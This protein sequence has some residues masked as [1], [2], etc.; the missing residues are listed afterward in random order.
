MEKYIIDGN[1]DFYAELYKSLDDASDT[2]EQQTCLITGNAL[3]DKYVTLNCG[4]TFNY[5]PLYYDVFNHKKKYNKFEF[6]MC[7]LQAWQFRCPYCRKK[8]NELLPYYPEFNTG[9]VFGVNYYHD[10]V[11]YNIYKNNVMIPGYMCEYVFPGK[12]NPTYDATKPVGPDNP[13]HTEPEPCLHCYASQI[14]IYTDEDDVDEPITYGDDHY[15]CAFHKKLMIRHYIKQTNMA[16]R[17]AEKEA[18]QALKRQL[19]E[20]VPKC[21]FIL[22]MGPRKGESC[23]CKIHV[24]QLCKRHHQIS[25]SNINISSNMNIEK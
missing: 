1:I 5:M 20:A 12:P 21:A 9:R 19:K 23:G 15:Y 11:K 4:H 24:D 14:Q 8:Q 16:K 17:A 25:S 10:K 18:K 7:K 6:E 13:T 22:K 3:T 2:E